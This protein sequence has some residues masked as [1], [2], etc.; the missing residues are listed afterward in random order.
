MLLLGSIGGALWGLQVKAGLANLNQK[1]TVLLDTRAQ[2]IPVNPS[3][4]PKA[5]SLTYRALTIKQWKGVQIHSDVIIMTVHLKRLSLMVALLLSLCLDALT[6][7]NAGWN[8]TKFLA[9]LV[10]LAKWTWVTLSPLINTVNNPQYQL[11][12]GPEALYLSLKICSR[13]ES[14]NPK[15]PFS[16]A[17]FGWYLSHLLISGTSPLTIESSMFM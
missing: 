3:K 13:Q 15:Y 5:N 11:K 6:W 12:Q 4:F 10:R 2:V 16:I 7:H 1:N 8:K 9:F 17:S 14:L